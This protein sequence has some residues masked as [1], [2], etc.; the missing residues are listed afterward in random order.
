MNYVLAACTPLIPELRRT[1]SSPSLLTEDLESS[2]FVLRRPQDSRH[3]EN[4]L[5][6]LHETLSPLVLLQVFSSLLL[7]RKVI[8]ISCELR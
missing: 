1:S 2:E 8:L 5:R 6:R 3:E 7:E 4:D